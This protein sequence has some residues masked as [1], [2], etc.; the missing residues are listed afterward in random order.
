MRLAIL[1]LVWLFVIAYGFLSP[2]CAGCREL[3]RLATETKNGLLSRL[4]FFF[5]C[6][7]LC[8]LAALVFVP[9]LKGFNL[10]QNHLWWKCRGKEYGIKYRDCL[11]DWQF[12]IHSLVW[13]YS[14]LKAC[15]FGQE[16]LA[17]VVVRVAVL[18]A[19]ILE[20]VDVWRPFYKSIYIWTNSERTTT[21]THAQLSIVEG[22]KQSPELAYV[23]YICVC[24]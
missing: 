8:L 9:Y 12:Y 1:A 23:Q 5:F 15:C 4:L 11:R 10:L 17:T 24:P 16:F 19:S 22:I 14:S 21:C 20:F 3:G 13:W 7:F 18:S 6:L 2:T